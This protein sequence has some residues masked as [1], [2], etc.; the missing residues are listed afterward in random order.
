[1]SN[2]A[3]TTTTTTAASKVYL[4]QFVDARVTLLCNNP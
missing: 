2:T 3:S 1:M 4:G